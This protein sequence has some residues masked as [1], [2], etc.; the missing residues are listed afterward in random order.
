MTTTRSIGDV[1]TPHVVTLPPD[2]TV[3]EAAVR[4]REYDIGDVVVVDGGGDGGGGVR[5]VLTD[6]DIVVRVVAAD[7]DPDDATVGEACTGDVVTVRPD[8]SVDEA[9]G[10]LREAAVRRMPVVD[11]GGRPVGMISIGDLAITDDSRSA[12]ADISAAPPNS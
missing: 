8:T 6:R 10:K 3:R 9:V 11:E 4:M 7:R 2:A 5:G 12:L 1:M